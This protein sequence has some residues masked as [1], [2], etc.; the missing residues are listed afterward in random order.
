[1]S[2]FPL[3]SLAVAWLAVWSASGE[4]APA[5]AAALPAN[6]T[7][8]YGI[9]WRLIRAGEARLVW[10]PGAS[11]GWQADLTLDSAGLVSRLYKV[12][13]EYTTAL[14][15]R[16]CAQNTVLKAAEGSRRRETRVTF[17]G[18][19]KT[20]S[21]VD[22]DLVKNTTLSQDITIPPC[23]HDVI[24]GLAQLRVMNLELGHSAQIPVSDGKKAVLAKVE[25]QER[26]TIKT[27]R[28]TF[29]TVR[30]EAFLFNNVL[31]RRPA[32]LFVWLTDDERKLPVQIRVRMPFYIGTVTLKLRKEG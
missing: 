3:K 30:Y 8:S 22:R 13:V 11:S 18:D 20:A 14:D 5:Q 1:M 28:G 25:A 9:E 7:L 17:D 19:R 23:T 2:R 24:G 29:R 12:H 21:M 15:S 10:A 27:E 26:E 32:R 6:E 4:Q 31:Y 16:L